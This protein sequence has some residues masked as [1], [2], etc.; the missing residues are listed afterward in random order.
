MVFAA[1]LAGSVGDIVGRRKVMLTAYAWFS[2]GMALTALSTTTTMF[3]LLRF[4]TGLG[5]GA[6]VA[7]TG[8]LVAEVA[9]A[10]KK[11]LCNAIT[12]SG[13]PLGSLLSALLAIM[14][15]DS[16]GWRGMFM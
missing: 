6:L 1:L 4:L 12:Y 14:L 15:L 5:V 8:A 10:G 13:V 7:T 2:I 11:N 9:P 3:G 16:I